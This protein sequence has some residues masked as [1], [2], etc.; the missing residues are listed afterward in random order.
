MPTIVPFTCYNS[1]NSQG[2]T[3]LPKPWPCCGWKTSPVAVSG[4]W[5]CSATPSFYCSGLPTTPTAFTLS[6]QSNCGKIY[7]YYSEDLPFYVTVQL[8]LCTDPTG[9]VIGSSF[10]L[11]IGPNFS[12][13][14]T[15]NG[16]SFVGGNYNVM[17]AGK[18]GFGPTEKTV[19]IN[20]VAF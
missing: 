18:V 6:R 8:S 5:F 17:L 12:P 14:P 9:T 1:P 16:C 4:T 7:L 2:E 11:N 10:G 3:A 15:G 13:N 19:V 20:G